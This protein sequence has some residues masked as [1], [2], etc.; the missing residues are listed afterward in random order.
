MAKLDRTAVRP[1]RTG[2]SS[3]S[4]LTGALRSGTQ[5]RRIH[6]AQRVGSALY[7]ALLKRS[8]STG[9]STLLAFERPE[10]SAVS[11]RSQDGRETAQYGSPRSW[12]RMLLIFAP[13]WFL[14]PSV[15]VGRRLTERICSHK[16]EN[17]RFV[18]ICYNPCAVVSISRESPVRDGPDRS[19][20][21]AVVPSLACRSWGTSPQ[22][23]RCPT[24]TS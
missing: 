20:R 11:T 15:L 16:Q 2:R 14:R 12:F 17:R 22:P 6:R 4:P 21:W 9:G 13:V 10:L 24:R 3:G 19:C 7:C 1:I 18:M 8:H 5:N 23:T